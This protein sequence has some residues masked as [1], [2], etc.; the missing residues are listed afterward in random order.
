MSFVI[1]PIIRIPTRLRSKAESDAA[2]DSLRTLVY[3]A[4]TQV[5]NED[6]LTQFTIIHTREQGTVP[7]FSNPREEFVYNLRGE[8]HYRKRVT[9]RL[10]ELLKAS[11]LDE[12]YAIPD[13]HV[14]QG[15]LTVESK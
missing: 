3:K 7:L 6:G 10:Q 8:L 15:K 9:K 11:P 14:R 1:H 12:F 5:L 2:P 4:I 13:E